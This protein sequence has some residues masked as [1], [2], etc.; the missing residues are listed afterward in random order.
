M[1]VG[2]EFTTPPS[3]PRGSYV[4]Y[5]VTDATWLS[6]YPY[7]LYTKVKADAMRWDRQSAAEIVVLEG[8][9]NK[10]KQFRVETV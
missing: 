4:V 8:W 1:A 10:D 5:N 3:Q 9:Q 6:R 2:Y 7:A